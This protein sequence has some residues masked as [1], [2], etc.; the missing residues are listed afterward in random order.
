MILC[1][2]DHTDEIIQAIVHGYDYLVKSLDE[3]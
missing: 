1:H 3:F 2:F